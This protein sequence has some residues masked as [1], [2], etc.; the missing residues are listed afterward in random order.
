MKIF[1][2][3]FMGSG[4]ST[5]GKKLAALLD[6]TFIDL[7]A[8]IESETDRSVTEWFREGEPKF[9]EIESLVLKQTADFKNS[10]IATGGGTPCFHENMNWM[11]E[12]G[13][14]VYLK[15]TPGGLFHRLIASKTKR[16]LLEGKTDVELMEYISETLKEREYFYAQAHYVIKGESLNVDQMLETIRKGEEELR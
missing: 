13:L 4:K 1:L 3:G 11:K 2:V 9:R 7:D 16:P 6:Y 10:I 5:A 12:Q 15:M 8:M 14:T